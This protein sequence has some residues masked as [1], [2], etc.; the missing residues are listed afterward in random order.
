MESKLTLSIDSEV[1]DGAKKLA[2]VKG[3]SLSQII[4]DILLELLKLHAIRINHSPKSKKSKIK[5]S[6]D[7]E[8]I[9]G[10]IKLSPDFDLK[11]HKTERLKQKYL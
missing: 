2:K 9:K 11:K 1:I 3:S 4:E 10:I 6:A 8:K 5:F 7:L